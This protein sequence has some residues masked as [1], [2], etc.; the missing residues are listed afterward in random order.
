MLEVG[1]VE[2][3]VLVDTEVDSGGVWVELAATGDGDSMMGGE[4][5]GEGPS[6]VPCSGD[7]DSPSLTTE[8]TFSLS[9]PSSNSPSSLPT[10]SVPLTTVASF[11]EGSALGIEFPSSLFSALVTPSAPVLFGLFVAA[12]RV[13]AGSGICK[14]RVWC[15][16]LGLNLDWE[17][18]ATHR[19]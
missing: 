12:E 8:E 3:G 11:V 6:F 2:L 17:V 9:I 13:A 14:S 19:L 4:E 7:V 18:L 16:C 10:A 15:V 5:G 1:G